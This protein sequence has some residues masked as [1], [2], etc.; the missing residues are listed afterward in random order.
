ML[1]CARSNEQ[2]HGNDDGKRADSSLFSSLLPSHIRAEL[3]AH[4]VNTCTCACANFTIRK[5]LTMPTMRAN[6]VV[7]VRVVCSVVV[8]VTNVLQ[9]TTSTWRHVTYC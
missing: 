9:F 2:F 8:A 6:T 5:P 1:L 7:K 3:H 4:V